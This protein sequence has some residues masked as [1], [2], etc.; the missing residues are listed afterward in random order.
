MQREPGVSQI[1]VVEDGSSDGS[2]EAWRAALRPSD[3]MLE[4]NNVHEIRAYNAGA[5]AA[6]AE[7]VCFL[8]DDDLPKAPGWAADVAAAWG[9]LP[10]RVSPRARLAR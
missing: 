10:R 6:A 4:S 2:K 5:R 3:V 8:Q 7:V 1:V 9:P